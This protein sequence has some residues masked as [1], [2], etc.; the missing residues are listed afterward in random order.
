MTTAMTFD[1]Y[2]NIVLA[3]E[4][5]EVSSFSFVDNMD[6]LEDALEQIVP[7]PLENIRK[8]YNNELDEYYKNGLYG[9]EIWGNL[10]YGCY[11]ER[12]KEL[13]QKNWDAVYAI[14]ADDLK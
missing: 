11:V 8:N 12:I 4:D 5:G 2:D 10:Y 14:V 13:V 6:V 1:E 7:E 3:D 9:K